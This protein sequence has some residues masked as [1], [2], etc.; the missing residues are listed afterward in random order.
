MSFP[1][2]IK[3]SLEGKRSLLTRKKKNRV[4]TNAFVERRE[5]L[6]DK[7]GLLEGSVLQEKKTVLT[8]IKER[9]LLGVEEERN[10][11]KSRCIARGKTGFEDST[12]SC[13]YESLKCEQE[14]VCLPA[15]FKV[16]P[17]ICKS[18]QRYILQARFP[19]KV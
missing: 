4:P 7:E 17:S 6:T 18:S 14:C 10:R 9:V 16:H 1:F 5:L 15:T 8:E 13:N 2:K 11:K 12:E 19:T 3:G